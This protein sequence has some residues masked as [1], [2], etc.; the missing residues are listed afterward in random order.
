MGD[1][2]GHASSGGELLRLNQQPLHLLV[3]ANVAGN[4]GCADDAAFAVFQRR[5][6]E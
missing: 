4:L 2:R 6:G 5:D 1:V 3:V